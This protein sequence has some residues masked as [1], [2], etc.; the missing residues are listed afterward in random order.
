MDFSFRVIV[1]E[2]Q[3]H[4]VVLDVFLAIESLM[5]IVFVNVN[6]MELGQDIDQNAKVR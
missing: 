6:R 5:E 2:N 4:Y 3:V 1:N